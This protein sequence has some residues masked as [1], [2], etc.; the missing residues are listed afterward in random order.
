[1][2]SSMSSF[3]IFLLDRFGSSHSINSILIIL[4]DLK[5]FIELLS[6]LANDLIVDTLHALLLSSASRLD[7][8]LCLLCIGLVGNKGTVCA[9]HH[10]DIH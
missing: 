3:E 7:H 6:Y 9:S 8:G 5:G 1:M 4:L 10:I 2:S